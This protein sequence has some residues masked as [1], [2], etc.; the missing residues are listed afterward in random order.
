MVRNWRNLVGIRIMVSPKNLYISVTLILTF[1]LERKLFRSWKL[2]VIFWCNFMQWCILIVSVSRIKKGLFDLELW[3]WELTLMAVRSLCSHDTVILLLLFAQWC[4]MPRGWKQK[5]NTCWNGLLLCIRCGVVCGTEHGYAG[6]R[7][8]VEVRCGG[9]QP[10]HTQ[11][12]DVIAGDVIDSC[13]L[14]AAADAGR[15]RRCRY[16][17]SLVNGAESLSTSP[18]PLSR[19]ICMHKTTPTCSAIYVASDIRATY[20]VAIY[21]R[22]ESES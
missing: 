14:P 15:H 13:S 7:H 19:F 6:G 10:N 2:L 16:V 20:M 12:G 21:I 11:L 3:P 1:N 17:T 9:F 22:K 8:D 4:K 18:W 5:L